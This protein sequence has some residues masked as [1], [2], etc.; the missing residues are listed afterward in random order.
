MADEDL[1]DCPTCRGAGEYEVRVCPG[2]RSRIVKCERCK[3]SRRVTRAEAERVA[4]GRRR[5]QDRVSRGVSLRD[6]AARLGLTPREL[7][8]IEHAR[9]LSAP[10]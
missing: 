10:S 4:E 3:G 7:A 9:P 6:E 8:D 1:V 5:Y 2:W